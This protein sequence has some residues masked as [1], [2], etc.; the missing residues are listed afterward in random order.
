MTAR[1]PSPDT[2]IMLGEMRGQLRELIHT[3]NNQVMKNDANAKIIAQLESLP[4]DISE[5]KTRLT[6]LEADKN[7]RDGAV[8]L[9]AWLLRSPLVAW[10]LAGAVIG[11]T[12]LRGHGQ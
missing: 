8:G 7:R 3:L 6:A 2:A 5:I 10:I 1:T 9:G 11:W 4:A 12:W